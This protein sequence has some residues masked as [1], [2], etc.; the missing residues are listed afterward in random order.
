MSLSKIR[1]KRQRLVKKEGS[2]VRPCRKPCCPT[3]LPETWCTCPLVLDIA[4]L[5]AVLFY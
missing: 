5:G 2:D 4:K 1:L 3:E